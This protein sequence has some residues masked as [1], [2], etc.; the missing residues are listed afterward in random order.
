MAAT[1]AALRAARGNVKSAAQSLGI[2]RQRLYRMLDEA[3]EI[4]LTTLRRNGEFRSQ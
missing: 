2:S 3:Q 4:D 1:L